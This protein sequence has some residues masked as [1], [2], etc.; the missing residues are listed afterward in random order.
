MLAERSRGQ[1]GKGMTLSICHNTGRFLYGRVATR[2]YGIHIFYPI[3]AVYSTASV[4]N[5]VTPSGF[6][7]F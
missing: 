7:G 6:G 1:Q 4:Y 3:V 2:P 5:R